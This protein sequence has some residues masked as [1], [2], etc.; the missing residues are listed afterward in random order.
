[1]PQKEKVSAGEV[2]VPLFQLRSMAQTRA[3][4]KALRN[5]LAW[6]VVLAGYRP[7]PAEELDGKTTEEPQKKTEPAKTKTS[8]GA[9]K[10]SGETVSVGIESVV[11]KEGEKN[12]K[13]YI[14]YTVT[15]EKGN[16]YKTFDKK[17]ADLCTSARESGVYAIITFKQTQYGKD[18]LAVEHDVP[19]FEGEAAS[20]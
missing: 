9:A 1:M 2:A 4:A 10:P 8:N 19:A 11:S 18:I 6:V 14:L 12:N 13:K 17:L 16:S 15:D 5:V 7:T 3:C 20:A